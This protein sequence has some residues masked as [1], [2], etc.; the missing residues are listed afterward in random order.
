MAHKNCVGAT[1]YKDSQILFVLTVINSVGANKY[2]EKQA[3]LCQIKFGDP[4]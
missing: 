2:L 4:K 3:V 1:F